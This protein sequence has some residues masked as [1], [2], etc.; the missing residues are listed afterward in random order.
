MSR[1]GEPGASRIIACLFVL[2]W[3]S[4]GC[5]DKAERGAEKPGRA[6]ELETGDPGRAAEGASGKACATCGGSEF[7][8]VVRAVVTLPMYSGKVRVVVIDPNPLWV[9]VVE[10]LGPATSGDES[11]ARTKTAFAIHS[12]THQFEQPYDDLVGEVF[13]FHV[14]RRTGARGTSWLSLVVRPQ[15]IW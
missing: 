6:G 9:V 11:T 1:L 2:S 5:R 7:V 14:C 12:P 15:A 13:V 8:G 4:V 3:P 10:Q